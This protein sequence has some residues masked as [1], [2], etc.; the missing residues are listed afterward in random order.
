[1]DNSM[2]FLKHIQHSAIL[3]HILPWVHANGEEIIY[4]FGFHFYEMLQFF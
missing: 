4:V 2:G 3:K 1:M